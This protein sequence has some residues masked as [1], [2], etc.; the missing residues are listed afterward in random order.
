VKHGTAACAWNQ[1][2]SF[3]INKAEW[4]ASMFAPV[5]VK[6]H[7]RQ[8]RENFASSS[9]IRAND[10][11]AVGDID[12]NGWLQSHRPVIRLGYDIRFEAS[13]QTAILLWT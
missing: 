8:F 9:P 3:E 10:S 4:L 12:A 11:L 2:F 1:A 5:I 13:R 7:I 6:G